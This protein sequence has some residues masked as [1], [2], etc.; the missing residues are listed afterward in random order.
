MESFE[1]SSTIGLKTVLPA[2]HDVFASTNYYLNKQ[3]EDIP[4]PTDDTTW[5]GVSRREHLLQLANASTIF[6]VQ[7]FEALMDKPVNEGGAVMP[8]TIYQLILDEKDLSLYI[9]I[10]HLGPTWHKIPLAVLFTN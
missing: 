2:A 9:K 3:W 4:K 7:Q 5:Q 8:S 10:N 1:Y 6:N